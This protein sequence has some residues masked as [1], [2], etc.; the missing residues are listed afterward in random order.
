[1]ART[2]DAHVASSCNRS[3][4]PD[5]TC[6]EPR[7]RSRTW[8]SE[9]MRSKYSVL[10]ATMRAEA[11]TQSGAVASQGVIQPCRPPRGSEGGE[12]GARVGNATEAS[13]WREAQRI[14]ASPCDHAEVRD[15][16]MPTAGGIQIG[17][18]G[19]TRLTESHECR[20]S[21]VGSSFD[22]PRW[23]AHRIRAFPCDHVEARRHPLPAKPGWATRG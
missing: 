19:I 1:M 9:R 12:D 6:T 3:T 8:P 13:R 14:W 17:E 7:Q 18:E 15:L 20:D 2:G 21:R 5:Y 22:A 11:Y 4:A 10:L 23:L 16:S